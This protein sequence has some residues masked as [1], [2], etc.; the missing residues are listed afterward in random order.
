MN[1]SWPIGEWYA[2]CRQPLRGF[3]AVLDRLILLVLVF[4]PIYH[5][6][7]VATLSEYLEKRNGPG[8]KTLLA[9]FAAVGVWLPTVTWFF[10]D[11]RAFHDAGHRIGW[12]LA[13]KCGFRR[14]LA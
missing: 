13:Y 11:S 4:G 1:D 10:R 12:Q 3:F 7:N 6:T 9:F 8:S 14:W 5:R 2:R